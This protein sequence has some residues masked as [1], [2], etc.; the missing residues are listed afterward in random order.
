MKINTPLNNIYNLVLS[1]KQTKEKK[2]I[3]LKTTHEKKYT[4]YTT[5]ME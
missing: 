2:N 5:F 4:F 3:H 1:L